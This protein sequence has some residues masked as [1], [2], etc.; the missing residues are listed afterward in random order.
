MQYEDKYNILAASLP[1]IFKPLAEPPNSMGPRE[2]RF[3]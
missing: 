2:A 1:Q 3:G